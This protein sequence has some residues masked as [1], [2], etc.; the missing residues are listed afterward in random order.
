MPY[1]DKEKQR[2]FQREWCAKRRRE[3]FNGKRCAQCH[4][5][6]DLEL[7][8]ID[9][10]TKVHHCIWSWSKPRR[11]AE[12]AKCQPLCRSCHIQKSIVDNTARRRQYKR[13]A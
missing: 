2:Q 8:H 12:L 5:P 6:S 4:T 9:P 10:A 3:Y 11:D 13:A 7:D 1:K